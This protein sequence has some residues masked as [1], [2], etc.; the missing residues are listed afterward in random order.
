MATEKQRNILLKNGYSDVDIDQMSY[1]MISQAIGEILA[2]PKEAKAEYIKP[3]DFGKKETKTYDTSSYYVAYAKDLCVAMIAL[4][5]YK[6][7][8]IGQIM[9]NAIAVIKQAQNEFKN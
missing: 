8:S 2:K 9:A 1:E 5:K 3:K 7:M 4:D 6:E